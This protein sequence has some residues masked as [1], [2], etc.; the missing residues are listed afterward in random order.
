MEEYIGIVKLFAGNYAIKGWA[1]C[2]GQ[3]L[4]INQYSA[5]YSLLGTT[6]GGNGTTTFALPDLR[7]RA[8]IGFGAGPGLQNYSLGEVGGTESVTL[9]STQMPAHSHSLNGT[10]AAGDLVPPTGALL[11]AAT[12]ADGDGNP[13]TVNS[14]VNGSPNTILNPASIGIT[15]GNQ[16]HENRSPFLT[17]NYIICL[18]GVYPSRN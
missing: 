3:L 10:T 14:Y 18:E 1:F 4:P 12:G 5:L 13:V 15:G 17:L 11:A 8:A 2:A 16:P 7:G 6:Y 9:I